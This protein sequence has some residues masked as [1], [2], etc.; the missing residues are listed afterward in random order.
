MFTGEYRVH[1]D[2]CRLIIPS[3]LRDQMVG[4]W[5]LDI[6]ILPWMEC[7]LMVA[8]TPDPLSAALAVIAP[9]PPTTSWTQHQRQLVRVVASK[10]IV[11]VMDKR[12]RIRLP[13]D[14]L[15][16]ASIDREGILVGAVNH[17]ELWSPERWTE[18]QGELGAGGLND[19]RTELE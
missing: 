17:L 14:A 11:D 8:G 1:L 10:L 15:T 7:V 19:L 9:D 16:A 4:V 5:P 13:Q 2:D 3:R 6:A 12:G 18:S